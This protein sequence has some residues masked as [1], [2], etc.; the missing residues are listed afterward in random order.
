MIFANVI[1]IGPLDHNELTI[2]DTRSRMRNGLMEDDCSALI[3]VRYDVKARV[4]VGVHKG[5]PASNFLRMDSCIDWTRVVS[6]SRDT[7]SVSMVLP[8]AIGMPPEPSNTTSTAGTCV[9]V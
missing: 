3:E 2:T 5:S 6:S 7:P 1:G 8:N 9:E 4:A